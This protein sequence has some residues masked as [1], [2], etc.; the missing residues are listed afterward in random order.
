MLVDC[1][2]YQG[3]KQF[4][5]RNRK[6]FPVGPSTITSI[7]LTHAH[8]DHSGY[9]PALIRS[10]C[11]A[12]VYCT[13]PTRD[14]CGLLLPDSGRLHEE[15]ARHARRKGYSKHKRP[16]PIYTE[17]DARAALR[18]FKPHPFGVPLDLGGGIS[19]E[20]IRAGHLLGAAQIRISIGGKT[21]HFSGD[22]GQDRDPLM[23]PP[24]PFAGADVLVCESTYGDRLHPAISPE[25]E[26]ASILE[27]FLKQK[28]IV[29]IPAF[30]VGRAQGIMY[31]LS[32]L[33]A[34][35]RIPSV[36]VFLDSPMASDATD[37]YLRHC[38]EHRIAQ[39]DCAATFKLPVRVNSTA[40]SKN[41]NSREG[42][43]VIISAS[44]MITGGRIL[45]H[46]V[47]F[48]CSLRTIIILSGYQAGGTRGASLATGERRLRIFGQY[49]DIG[50]QVAQLETFSGHADAD[51]LLGWMA[52]GPAPAMTYLTHGEPEAS[53]A[54]RRRISHE[55]HRPARVPE[56]L[57]AI[58]INN[59]E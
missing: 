4:R 27:P 15:G 22:L 25:D 31:H 11:K 12:P 23:P 19:A 41:L 13:P 18:R 24:E 26:L 37:I 9:L 53:E 30:A 55:L 44:G 28:G 36:P 42:P 3:Y 1:G 20:F 54:L 58:N 51:Q 50:A 6:P 2:L 46:M 29:L 38:T 33:M 56:H 32:R 16:A 40:Q 59:P 52:A 21:V 7:L 8:L 17:K 47:N 45:H 10:G 57:E 35:G 5:R 39:Q 49:Y 34:V 14:L 43:M 48:G